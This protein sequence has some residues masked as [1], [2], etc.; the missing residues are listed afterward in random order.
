[1]D[2]VK[3]FQSHK[4]KRLLKSF[5][6]VVVTGPRQ[7]G[8]ST[9]ARMVA[10]NWLYF[11]LEN[12]GHFDRIHDDPVL[13]FRENPE[14]IIIDEAQRSPRLFEVLRGVIDA[15]RNKK[16]RFI[17]T[18]SASFEL[19]SAISETLAGRVA[20]VELAPLK[21][22]EALGRPLPSF[23]ELFEKKIN[24]EFAAIISKLPL[25]KTHA[26]LKQGLL[27]GG[28]PEPCLKGDKEFLLDWMD[29]YFDTYINRD[30]RYLF[31]RLDI[32]RYRRVVAMLSSLSGTIINKSEISRS[33]EVKEKSV[34]DYLEIISGTYF[35]RELPA[36]LTPKIKTT[37][38]LSKGHFCDSGLGLFLQ[39]IHSMQDLDSYPKLGNYFEAFIVEELIRGF[40]AVKIRN[41]KFH[42]FRTKAGG[43]ID[44][45]VTGSFGTLPIEVKYASNVRAKQVLSLKNF[46]E[47]H[48]LDL[49]I[50]ISNAESASMIADKILQLP[51]R[52]I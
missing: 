34:R 42:H 23:Y 3:R 4:I 18:G 36:F 49:G 41:L 26:E 2:G 17:L 46:V 13:F 16:G 24:P 1:M 19:I 29:N 15:D 20:I 9:I 35:W 38:K 10:D 50:V 48:N 22:D 21:V 37:Q 52:C 25:T 6:A 32:V 8:K 44:L 51:A 28:F 47:I 11:D 31:P 12:P 45:I 7:A 5:A 33:I 30:I 14:Y 40:Q 27:N 39:N 43:E